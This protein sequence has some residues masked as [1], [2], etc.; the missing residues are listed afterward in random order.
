MVNIKRGC[1]HLFTPPWRWRMAFPN[2]LL[3]EIERTVNQ[4]ER[5]HRGEIR[6]AIE[7]TLDASQIWQGLTARDRALEVFSDLQVWDTE[8]NSGVLI[9]L[10]LADHEVHI[11]A[12][13][14][15]AKQVAQSEWDAVAEAMRTAFRQGDFRGGSLTGIERVSQLLTAHFPAEQENPNELSDRPAILRS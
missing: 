11:I 12:D 14:G 6:F 15:I 7:N 4:S 8:E 13:R 10:L 9:Y 3:N 2:A 5:Q 1:I